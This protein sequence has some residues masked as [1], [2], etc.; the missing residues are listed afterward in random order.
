MATAQLRVCSQ[1]EGIENHQRKI[2]HTFHPKENDWG[3]SQFIQCEVLLDE[4]SGY[5]KN[6]I[7]R[8]EVDVTADAPHGVW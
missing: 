5:I 4:N 8:L 6:D 1:R 7:V 2:S 3:Y